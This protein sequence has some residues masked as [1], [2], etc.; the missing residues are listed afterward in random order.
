MQVVS[1]LGHWGYDL[2]DA[3]IFQTAIPESQANQVG[4][5]EMS[6]ASL[7]ELIMLGVAILA[8]DVSYFGGLATLSMIS[9][10]SAALVYWHWLSNPTPDQVRLFPR[11]QELAFA[12]IPK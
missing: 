3:Q 11:E 10:A 12:P 1:R 2:V 9:V 8:S 7:A 6:L 4:T 5:A